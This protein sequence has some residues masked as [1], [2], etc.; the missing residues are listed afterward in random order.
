MEAPPFPAATT[1]FTVVREGTDADSAAGRGATPSFAQ[2]S[3][4]SEGSV[5]TTHGRAAR[6]NVVRM[7][8]R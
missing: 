1:P 7:R 8:W 2:I 5:T 3:P 6:L 4:K